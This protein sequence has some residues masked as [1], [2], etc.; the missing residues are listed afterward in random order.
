MEESAPGLARAAFDR[1]I[2]PGLLLVVTRRRNGAPRL[3][4]VEPLILE[5]DLWL[6]M[7]WGSRKA[8]DLVHDA[9]VLIHSVVTNPTQPEPELKL[10][11]RGVAV[12][13]PIVRRR[14]CDAVVDLGWQPQEP[15][16]HLFRIDVDEVTYISYAQNGDQHVARWPQ[17]IEFVR[18]AISATR[19]GT[20]EPIMDLLVSP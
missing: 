8:G 17:R 6:S 20:P 14:Y 5:G 13:D 19:L 4:P 18:R 10:R 9:R 2:A 3:S 15:Y 16:F 11:G 7:M 1:L 12:A